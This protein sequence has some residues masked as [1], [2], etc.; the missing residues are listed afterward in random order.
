MLAFN[1]LKFARNNRVTYLAAAPAA[2]GAGR[3]PTSQIIASGARNSKSVRMSGATGGVVFGTAGHLDH[4]K[5]TLVRSLIGVDTD[6]LVEEKKLGGSI[7]L[8]FADLMLPDNR[9]IAIVDV[10][11]HERFIKNMLAGT[12]GIDAVLLVIAADEGIQPQT[13]ELPDSTRACRGGATSGQSSVGK[14]LS[15]VGVDG[16][17]GHSP[18]R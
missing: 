15:H 13:R 18:C 10:P 6:R 4:G 14:E 12:I 3:F 11:G 5:T 1:L 9:R 2:P 17:S 8:G 16:A 7:E